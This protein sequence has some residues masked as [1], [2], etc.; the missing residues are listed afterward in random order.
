[1]LD[2][3]KEFYILGDP[4]ETEIGICRF[5]KVS[6]YKKYFLHLGALSVTKNSIIYNHYKENNFKPDLDLIKVLKEMPLYE[7]VAVSNETR[8]LYSE[9]FDFVFDKKGIFANSVNEKNFEYYRKLIMEM[10]VVKEDAV[11]PNPEI[12]RWNE[13]SK[14]HKS[15][16]ADKMTFSDI[17][18]SVKVGS[19]I[20]YEDIKNQTLFQLYTD[21][22]RIASFKNFDVTTLFSTVSAEKIDI[23]N[24]SKHIDLYI[25][26]KHTISA[27]KIKKTNQDLGL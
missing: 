19:H 17:V 5:V 16:M 20:S 9:L 26:E 11:S 6:E 22:Y 27:D 1:M 2:T 23:E 12:Q 15:S 7:M 8:E 24:W 14:K 10:N 18:S 3:I 13:K 4:I 21:F 25:E